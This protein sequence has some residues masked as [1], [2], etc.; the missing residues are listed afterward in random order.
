M[1]DHPRFQIANG[2]SDQCYRQYHGAALVAWVLSAADW[3]LSR[4]SRRRVLQ[5]LNQHQINPIH[6]L[7]RMRHD[8]P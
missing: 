5:H 1:T 7:W 6:R 4:R 2:G 3:W 8:A